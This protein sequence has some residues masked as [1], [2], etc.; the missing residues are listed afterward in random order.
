MTLIKDIETVKDFLD[1][2]VPDI[3][4]DEML[5]YFIFA[6]KKY[7]PEISNH[8]QMIYRGTF[9]NTDPTYMISKIKS[10]ERDYYKLETGEKYNEECLSIYIDCHP[11][12]GL[13]SY[14]HFTDRMNKLLYQIHKDTDQIKQFGKIRKHFMSEIHKANSRKPYILIDIDST[15]YGLVTDIINYFR[16]IKNKE[17]AWVSKTHG[18][19]HIILKKDGEIGK[20]VYRDFK[21]TAMYKLFDVEIK[22]DCT[23]PI[24]GTLQGGNPVKGT[25][26]DYDLFLSFL[27]YQRGF[28]ELIPEVKG[29]RWGI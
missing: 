9:T 24:P 28:E 16:H 14:I 8:H 1:K 20:I 29:F 19:Y 2:V 25:G 15:D 7:C 13:K 23:T 17:P 18:G 21:E 10:L 11:K 3:K 5:M 12:S 26:E 27:D 22:G 6:R 4:D